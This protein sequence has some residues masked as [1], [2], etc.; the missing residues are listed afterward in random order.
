V[1]RQRQNDLTKKLFGAMAVARD[2]KPMRLDRVF[3][4]SGNLT[5]RS[6]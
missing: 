6:R 4:A 3:A 5:H 1:H 2:D